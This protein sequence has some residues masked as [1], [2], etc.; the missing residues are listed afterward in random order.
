MKYYCVVS[1]L[2][3]IL[4]EAETEDEARMWIE[5]NYEPDLQIIYG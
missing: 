1:E 5:D 3:E 4:Y 2:S